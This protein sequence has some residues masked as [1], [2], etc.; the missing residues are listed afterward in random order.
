MFFHKKKKSEEKEMK[1]DKGTTNF[2]TCFAYNE[3]KCYF[4]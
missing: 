1:M 2:T 3:K 4:V